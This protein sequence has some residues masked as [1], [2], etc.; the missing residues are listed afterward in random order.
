MQ[1]YQ[2]EYLA[3]LREVTALSAWRGREGLSFDAYAARLRENEARVEQLARRDMELLRGQFF[4]LLD[5]LFAADGAALEDL[6]EF[7]ARLLGR[8]EEL[9]AGLFCQIRQALLSMARQNRDRAGAIRE[10]YWLGMGRHS[11]VSKLVGLE[12]PLVEKFVVQMRL[13]FTEAAAYLK[14]YDELED[15]ET[16]GYILRSRANIALGPFKSPGEKIRLVK[17]TLQ[18]L[19]DKGYQEKAPELPWDRYIY[20]THQHMASS[21]SYRKDTAMSAEDMADIMESV[22]I[23]NQRQVREAEARGERT[24]MRWIFPYH[25]IEYYCGMHSLEQ[26]LAEIEKLLDAVD[27]TDFSADGM[28]GMGSLLAFYC[29]YL[30]QY[31]EYLP[32]RVGYLEG[33]YRRVMAYVDAFPREQEAQ[34]LFWHLRQLAYT[35]VETGSG[36]SYGDFVEKIM[37]RF[38]PEAYI[39]AQTVG[40]AA[41]VLCD[42]IMEDEPSFFDDIDFL[43][44]VRDPEEKRRA[45]L[46]F[47]MGCGV[48]HDTGK[49]DVIELFSRTS[50]QWFE[51]E[52][53]MAR[54]HTAAGEV[55]LSQRPSTSRYAAAALGHHAWYDGAH[56]YPRAYH[57]LACPYRQ[58]VDVVALVDWLENVTHSA[59]LYTGEEMAFDEAVQAAI[60]LEGKQFSPLLTARLRDSRVADRISRALA[61]GRQL[62]YRRMYEDAGGN[63]DTNG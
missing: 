56:G 46:E 57:R 25:A 53:E 36:L 19:Q 4:P 24:P 41:R 26:L 17:Q 44:A 20:M 42:L 31:P 61:E 35:F 8:P 50:R 3:N 5:N 38:A 33:L 54:L 12:L 9:D 52:Y 58:M 11:R 48:F 49:I 47:A 13:C 40:E 62:A 10:L 59:R 22:Y 51:E 18:I 60:G 45:V 14:Y 23:V 32:E 63:M 16:R 6:E 21:I 30:Q 43:R 29:Q 27:P 1:P 37:L 2:E 34:K 28:Y 7:A 15:A 39:H 55:L